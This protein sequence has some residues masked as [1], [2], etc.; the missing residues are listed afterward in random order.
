VREYLTGLKWD[1]KPRINT[2]MRDYLGAV[3]GGYP[4]YLEAV[5]WKVSARRSCAS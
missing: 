5:S 3:D 4:E 2:W 1:G